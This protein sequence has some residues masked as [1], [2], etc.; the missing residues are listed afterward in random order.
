M[1][2]DSIV[3]LVLLVFIFR[4]RMTTNVVLLVLKNGADAKK[5]MPN[6]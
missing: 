2:L 3:F 1:V 6:A 5:L 4:V